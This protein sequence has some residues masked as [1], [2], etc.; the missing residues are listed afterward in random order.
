MS[1]ERDV[2]TIYK[3]RLRWKYNLMKG[4]QALKSV[5]W[6]RCAQGRNKWK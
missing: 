5:H 2:K 4:I 3:W 6:K 1:E